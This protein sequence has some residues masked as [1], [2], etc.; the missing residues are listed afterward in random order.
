MR[1]GCGSVRQLHRRL[2][3]GVEDVVSPNQVDFHGRC[4]RTKEFD[5][6]VMRK[7]RGSTK[8]RMMQR[9]PNFHFFTASGVHETSGRTTNHL[10]KTIPPQATLLARRAPQRRNTLT[11][12]VDRQTSD[13]E[14][15]F[16]NSRQF[17]P[18]YSG[19]VPPARLAS[20]LQSGAEWRS[21]HCLFSHGVSVLLV[22]GVR[23][24]KL[25]GFPWTGSSWI[26]RTFKFTMN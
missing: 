25:F 12:A 11:L 16:A 23:L 17:D 6:L 20:F 18:L 3:C 22:R 26:P 5:G 7:I 4:R 8:T 19:W 24:R 21:L 15:G 9:D 2:W 10:K 1:V 13:V 14:G